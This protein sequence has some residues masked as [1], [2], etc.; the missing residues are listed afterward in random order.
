MKSAGIAHPAVKTNGFPQGHDFCGHD[1]AGDCR[2][3]L[4]GYPT[5]GLVVGITRLIALLAHR[6][7][8]L[9]SSYL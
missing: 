5:A 6:L 9:L 4:S 1:E 2:G 3:G 8:A 7:A